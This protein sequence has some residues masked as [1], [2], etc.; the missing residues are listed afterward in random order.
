[1]RYSSVSIANFE[2]VHAH[3]DWLHRSWVFIINFEHCQQINICYLHFTRLA[4]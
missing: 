3:S 1:M 2:Q 4:Y